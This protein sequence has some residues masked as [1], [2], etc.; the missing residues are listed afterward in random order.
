VEG[1]INFKKQKKMKPLTNSELIVL[2]IIAFAII[3]FQS[4]SSIDIAESTRGKKRMTA[5]IDSVRQYKYKKLTITVAHLNN[6][7]RWHAYDKKYKA[8]DTLKNVPYSKMIL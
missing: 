5:L 2:L 7:F 6:G 3:T 1:Q 4:C 8:G